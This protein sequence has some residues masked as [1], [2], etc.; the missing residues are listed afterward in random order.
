MVS[1]TLNRS[2]KK[3]MNEGF[4]PGSGFSFIITWSRVRHHTKQASVI[5][6]WRDFAC[7]FEKTVAWIS[8][9]P[10]SLLPALLAFPF[11]LLP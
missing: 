6:L 5:L 3:M 8:Y 9:T 10:H 2:Y 7:P 4:G 11:Q 1:Q